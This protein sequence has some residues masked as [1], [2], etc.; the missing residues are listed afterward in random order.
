MRKSS[1]HQ[2]TGEMDW[3]DLRTVLAIVRGGGLSGAARDLGTQHSTVFRRLEA[4]EARLGVKLF[5]RGRTGYRPTPHGDVMADAARTM[6]EAALAA[7]RRVQGADAR[8]A[9][10]I[11]IA[12]SEV[13]ASYLLP[14]LLR[15]FLDAHPEIELELTVSN[16]QVD[17]ERREADLALRATLEP[18][19]S[20]VGRRLA[21]LQY[22][23]FATPALLM[24][25]GTTPDASRSE[26]KSPPL[27]SLPWVG[28]DPRDGDLRIMRSLREMLPSVRPRLR[29]D[30]LMT[31]LRMAA[32]GAGAVVLPAFAGA[33]EPCLVRITPVIEQPTMDLWLLHHPDVRG[34]ARVR[35]LI[36]HLADTVPVEIK[37]LVEE[38]P[39][40]AQQIKRA[41]SSHP[42][43]GKRGSSFFAQSA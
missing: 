36:Q 16:R 40:C 29:A 42:V 8:L 3:S 31:M 28:F 20:L 4:I 1:L 35:A 21:T 18:S 7:E 34:N 13:L 15:G 11:R 43:R 22:A 9:G 27:E 2:S 30:S 12:T 38:G 37:R 17:L 10:T 19:E 26:R 32:T 14:R 41:R 25:A 5:E 39:A 6:E 33:Q 24:N 23:I